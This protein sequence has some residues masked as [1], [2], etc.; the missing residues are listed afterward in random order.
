MVSGAKGEY[1]GGNNALPSPP[2]HFHN[3]SSPSPPPTF[4]PLTPSSPHPPS[5]SLLT[6]STA[7]Q[8]GLGLSG[9]VTDARACD[10]R[11]QLSKGARVH[12]ASCQPSCWCAHCLS[13]LQLLSLLLHKTIALLVDAAMVVVVFQTMVVLVH[14]ILMMLVQIT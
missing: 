1:L 13:I 3:L 14:I 2:P 5:L 11:S 4:S 6:L 12:S 9:W 7:V 8:P 10:A